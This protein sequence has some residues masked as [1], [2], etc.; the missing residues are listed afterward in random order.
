[1]IDRDH[2]WN[3]TYKPVSS[4][5]VASLL[6]MFGTYFIVARHHLHNPEKDIVIWTLAAMQGLIQ[7]VLFLH[8]GMRGKPRWPMISFLFMLLVVAIV[9]IGTV[10]IISNLNYNMMPEM[11]TMPGMNMPHMEH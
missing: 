1:M 6:L 2:G 4:G 3:L 10:W 5:L 7:L 9:I 11:E 8:L